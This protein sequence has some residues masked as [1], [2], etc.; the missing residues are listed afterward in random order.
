[1]SRHLQRQTARHDVGRAGLAAIPEMVNPGNDADI[2]VDVFRNDKPR[3][4]LAA[5]E[6]MANE[7]VAGIVRGVGHKADGFQHIAQCA[8]ER[9]RSHS[10]RRRHQIRLHRPGGGV[11]GE[12]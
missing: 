6:R 10:G 8:A 1:M 11:L 5:L 4:K 7:N 2:V 3:R 9:R 12:G